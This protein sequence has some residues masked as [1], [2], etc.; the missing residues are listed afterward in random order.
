L[1]IQTAT[2][3]APLYSAEKGAETAILWFIGVSLHGGDERAVAQPNEVKPQPVRLV[4]DFLEIQRGIDVVNC[5]CR[6]W[7]VDVISEQVEQEAD[8]WLAHCA[9]RCDFVGCKSL[10]VP[11]N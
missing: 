10:F 5:G 3:Q 2:Q 7:V 1:T 8:K 11:V 6:R 4:V 9:H